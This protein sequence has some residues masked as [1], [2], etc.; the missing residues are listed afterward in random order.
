MESIQD[1]IPE[2]Q[3]RMSRFSRNM[4]KSGFSVPEQKNVSGMLYG[5]LK[6]PTVQV[7]V[8]SRSLGEGI[9]LKK[10]W[11]RLS[12]NLRHEELGKRL[13]AAHIRENGRA[14]RKK[15]YCVIDLSDIQKPYSECMEGLSRVRDGDKSSHG[16]PVIGNGLYW[17]NAVMADE[18]G[19]LPVYSE[20]YSL[21]RE[22]KEHASENK[23]LLAVTNLVRA[24]HP[25]AVYVFDRGGDRSEIINPLVADGKAFV[26]RGQGQ[27]SLRLHRDSR[28]VTNIEEIAKRTHLNHSY[29][30][31]RNSE[32]FDVGIRRIYLGKRPMWLVVSNRRRGGLSWYLTNVEG[33]RRQIMDTVM[34]AYGLRW[35]VEE[36]HRQIKQ[37]YGFESICLRKYQA[38]KNMAV[39][40]MLAASFCARLPE[41][42]AIKLL[43]VLN[44]L[45]RKRL[46]DIPAYPYYMITDAVASALVLAIKRRPLPLR[47]RKQN[48]FQLNLPLQPF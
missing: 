38:I 7:S 21:E 20:L 22:G 31:S 26:I 14:V 48:F 37:D 43:A 46:R 36:Y 13:L 15:R 10:T 2:I 5:M 44:R 25:E 29:Q 33:T 18:T 16:K 8:L 40:V 30:S 35:R 32:M 6:Q 19:I 12:R 11:E 28:K 1:L 24:E 34:E 9:A 4:A 39:L 27:R 45:P 17:L 47:V 41:Q 42:L 23:K 3:Q